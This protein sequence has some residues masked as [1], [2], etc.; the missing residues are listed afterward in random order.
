MISRPGAGFFRAGA[1][2]LGSK[3]REKG[4]PEAL[5]RR[6]VGPL[7]MLIPWL[8]YTK[9]DCGRLAPCRFIAAERRVMVQY[10]VWLFPIGAAEPVL[11]KLD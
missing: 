7:Y 10:S 9:G 11:Q 1:C 2:D 3:R 6:K 5:F 8:V 4:H